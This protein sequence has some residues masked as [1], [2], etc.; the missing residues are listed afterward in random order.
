MANTDGEQWEQLAG[1]SRQAWEAF[2]KY[3][4]MG[5]DRSLRKVAEEL[6]KSETLIGRWSSGMRW[7][8]RI[9]A[10]ERYLDRERQKTRL[11]EIRREHVRSTQML[12]VAKDKLVNSLNAMNITSVSVGEWTAALERVLRLERAYF[13]DD[14]ATANAESDESASDSAGGTEDAPPVNADD[15][16][17]EWAERERLS[18]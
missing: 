8:E 12:K 11:K 17:R 6:Q 5:D 2:K 13:G 18:A 14:L 16:E 10:Y 4:D 3:R 7:Q 9:A 15:E 1:E